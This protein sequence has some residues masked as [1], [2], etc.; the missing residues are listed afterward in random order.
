MSCKLGYNSGLFLEDELDILG[1]NSDIGQAA[2]RCLMMCQT[3]FVPQMEGA[4]KSQETPISLLLLLQNQHTQSFASLSFL[5]CISFNSHQTLPCISWS[6]GR[7][8]A[9]NNDYWTECFNVLEQRWQYVDNPTGGKTDEALMRSATVHSWPYTNML[10]ISML[11]SQ[12]VV[13]LLLSL[14]P[15]LQDAIQKKHMGRIWENIQHVQGPLTW[16]QLHKMAG[17]ERLSSGIGV[18]SHF[19]HI[20]SQVERLLSREATEEL[21]QKPLALEY[22]VSTAKAE[23]LSQWFLVIMSPDSES[24]PSLPKGFTST[25]HLCSTVG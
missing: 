10:D 20:L 2:E 18:G 4:R 1:N 12:D 15:F 21:K 9:D 16:Q 5:D 11:S 13:H 25:P 22:F 8:Q 19:Q 3:K 7:V 14:K 6:Y 17:R 23:N 24:V